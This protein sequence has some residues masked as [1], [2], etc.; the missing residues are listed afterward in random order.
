[1]GAKVKND[2]IYL[3]LRGLARAAGWL[4][5]AW[6]RRTGAVL[7]GLFHDC[8]R[9]ERDKTRRQLAAAFP[10][11]T[12]EEI[13]RL[14]RRVFVNL[15][16]A[17]MEF[18]R[19]RALDASRVA[20]W[21]THVEG[22]EH[23]TAA[24]ARGR[25]VVCLTGH[26]GNW[27]ILPVFTTVQGWPTSVVAQRLYDPRLDVLLNRARARH[28]IRVIQRGRVTA[29]IVRSLRENRLLGVLND[30]DTGVDSRWAPFFG[31]PAKTPVG[32]LRLA[33]RT[34]SPVVP[35]FVV[36]LPSGGHAVHIEP[37][38]DLPRTSDEESDLHQ[39][40]ERCNAVIE[41]YVR[42][43]PDH[44]VWFHERWKTTPPRS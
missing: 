36:R 26:F 10:E 34:G 44:W 28:G 14:G 21:V 2:F 7:G 12:P 43:H 40:A 22:R 5:T 11:R 32:I 19:M 9:R 6:A 38:L 39:G 16:R 35:F 23:V 3:G 41:A 33:R 8:V 29:E 15:G 30:Q 42:R 37:A 20:A 17:G 13:R 25:G 24:L 31:R 27:E 4:P 18:M 1:M